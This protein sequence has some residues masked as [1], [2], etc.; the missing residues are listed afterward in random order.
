MNVASAD[1]RQL[2]KQALSFALVLGI[3]LIYRAV[4]RQR[5]PPGGS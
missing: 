3:W 2:G 1:F 4:T 5:P